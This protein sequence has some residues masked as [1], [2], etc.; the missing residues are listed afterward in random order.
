MRVLVVE[1]DAVNQ[2]LVKAVLEREGML[3]DLAG[4]ASNASIGAVTITVTQNAN[5]FA[6]NLVGWSGSNW[7]SNKALAD[8]CL[9]SLAAR[10][11]NGASEAYEYFA[12]TAVQLL[13]AQTPP[14]VLTNGPVTAQA[15]AEIK[16]PNCG[17]IATSPAIKAVAKPTGS[18]LRRVVTG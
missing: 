13:A 8:R 1:D 12:E 2:R 18:M 15:F 10:S 9:L 5:V 6:S 7:E 14:Y 16:P 4:T 3:A 11:P 17:F